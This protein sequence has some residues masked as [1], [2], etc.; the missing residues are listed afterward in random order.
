MIK[1]KEIYKMKKIGLFYS[2]KG[3]R[4]KQVAEDIKK[5]FGKADIELVTVEEV[6]DKDFEKYSN[7]ILGAATWF[8]GELP[9]YWDELMPEISDLK[10][11]GKKVAIFGLGDQVHYSANFV[12]G[13]GILA[14]VFEKAGAK[15]VGETSIDGYKYER[16]RAVR[17]GKFLG[18]AIDEV[19]QSDKTKDREKKWVAQLEKEF[20]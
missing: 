5:L 8:D 4:T 10:L 13:I 14:E 12:D 7:I 17:N 20:D 18:L 9:T 3:S 15:I 16:S 2:A 19:N 11:K 6:W 1:S